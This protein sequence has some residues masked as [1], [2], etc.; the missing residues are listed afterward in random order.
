MKH[1]QIAL[2]AL[3]GMIAVGRKYLKW[4]ESNLAERVGISRNTLRKIERGDPSVGIGIVFDCAVIT[5]IDL[6]GDKDTLSRESIRIQGVLAL[7]PKRVTEES[8]DDDF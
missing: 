8:V 6:L 1:T 5:G 3:G 4:S 7:L 2:A